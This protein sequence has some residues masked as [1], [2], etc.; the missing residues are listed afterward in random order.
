MILPTT[1]LSGR[2]GGVVELDWQFS[3]F[4]Q[5]LEIL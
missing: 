2:Q 5:V 3:E 4:K 1:I